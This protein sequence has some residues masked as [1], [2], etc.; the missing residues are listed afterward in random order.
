MSIQEY[1][2]EIMSNSCTK[3]EQRL[4]YHISSNYVLSV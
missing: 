3:G 1:E 4:K 2:M